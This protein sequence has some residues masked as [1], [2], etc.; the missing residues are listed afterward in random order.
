MARTTSRI[1][2]SL[3]VPPDWNGNVKRQPI[4]QR[5][6]RTIGM[7]YLYARGMR[8]MPVQQMGAD[9]HPYPW[10]SSFNKN[11][12]GPIRNG[13]F[14]DALF[15]AGYPGYNLGLSFKVPKLQETTTGPGYAMRSTGP[16]NV[17]GGSRGTAKLGRAT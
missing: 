17:K 2:D 7:K 15:Q 13:G 16:K 10:N 5:A 11:D 14:N 3:A 6:Q 12:Q 4:V 8:A 1:N 9:G